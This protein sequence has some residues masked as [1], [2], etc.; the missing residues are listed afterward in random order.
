MLD[1]EFAVILDGQV[2]ATTVKFIQALF[3]DGLHMQWEV[4]KNC[5]KD[6]YLNS[7]LLAE[8]K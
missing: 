1:A 7:T 3:L 8:D 4:S 6:I 2:V 5:Q